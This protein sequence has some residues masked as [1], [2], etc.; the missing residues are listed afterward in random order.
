MIKRNDVIDHI[1]KDLESLQD[2]RSFENQYAVKE[3]ISFFNSIKS[4][5]L[6]I[7][8][9]IKKAPKLKRELLLELSDF[10]FPKWD[11]E[12]HSKLIEIERKDFPGLVKPLVSRIVDLVT[13]KEHPAIILSIGS[14]GMEI[15][16]QVLEK[17]IN[18]KYGKR[19]IFVAVD[20]SNIAL[21]IAKENFRGIDSRIDIHEFK[22][23]D[24][25][26]LDKIKFSENE[27]HTVIMCKNDIFDFKKDFNQYSFD[28]VFH[29]LFKHH[30][31]GDEKKI[32]DNI[33]EDVSRCILEYDGYKSWLL[34]VPQTITGWG[35]PVFL[36][37]E[38]F[39]NLRYFEKK[40]LL[41]QY[42]NQNI[43][44]FKVGTYLLESNNL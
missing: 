8:W 36:N 11:R 28:I 10:P 15:E 26:L 18:S 23:L 29:S 22:I 21:E 19:I 41:N 5:P 6:Y 38:I 40:E 42:K 33:L 3:N 31:G 16:R 34:V 27:K 24:G 37:A 17:L 9:L 14:G 13:S 30:L 43:R 2:D 25:R 12:M 32:L 20:K 7:T 35:H 1:I 39:S 4:I 44:F